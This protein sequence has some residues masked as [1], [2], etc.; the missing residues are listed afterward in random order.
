MVIQHFFHGYYAIK[1]MVCNE[2]LPTSYVH[3]QN[4]QKSYL[5]V[6]NNASCNLVFKKVD[7]LIIIYLEECPCD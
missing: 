2:P 1:F 3:G 4:F 5:N 6:A 7:R